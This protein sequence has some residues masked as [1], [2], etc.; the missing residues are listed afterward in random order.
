MY[1]I[2]L[3][4][5]LLACVHGYTILYPSS[6]LFN[7][8]VGN[9]SDIN[10]YCAFQSA[11]FLNCSSSQAFLFYRNSPVT[12]S[13][14]IYDRYGTLIADNQT[15]L[16]TRTDLPLGTHWIGSLNNNCGDWLS[17]GCGNAQIGR[18]G[19]LYADFWACNLP[20]NNPLLPRLPILCAC[21]DGTPLPSLAPTPQ[22]G[23]TAPT[24]SPTRRPT[25]MPV[26]GAPSRVPTFAP[27]QVLQLNMARFSSIPGQASNGSNLILFTEFRFGSQSAFQYNRTTVSVPVDGSY[28]F[29]VSAGYLDF[30]VLF[31]N[32]PVIADVDVTM[33]LRRNGLAIA[34]ITNMFESIGQDMTLTFDH[35]VTNA[36]TSDVFDVVI[37]G[38]TNLTGSGLTIRKLD[39]PV[40]T[41]SLPQ[42]YALPPTLSP[43]I[44]PITSTGSF[45]TGFPVVGTSTITAATTALHYISFMTTLSI[46]LGGSA[47]LAVRKNGV[48]QTQAYIGDSVIDDIVTTVVFYMWL[49]LVVNDI[50]IIRWTADGPVTSTATDTHQ[51]YIRV[52]SESELTTFQMSSGLAINQVSYGANAPQVLGNN[53][54]F[55]KTDGIYRSTSYT[56]VLVPNGNDVLVSLFS[57]ASPAFI[58]GL[59]DLS[60]RYGYTLANNFQTLFSRVA[61]IQ[62]LDYIAAAFTGGGGVTF[63][64]PNNAHFGAIVRIADNFSEPCF[65]VD[66]YNINCHSTNYGNVD[67]SDPTYTNYAAVLAALGCTCYSFNFL[68]GGAVR[69]L[70]YELIVGGT[71]QRCDCLQVDNS[72]STDNG[73]VNSENQPSITGNYADD[74]DAIGWTNCTDG[75]VMASFFYSD[76]TT[77]MRA[78]SYCKTPFMPPSTFLSCAFYS[79]TPTP[80]GSNYSQLYLHNVTCPL[81]NQSI[82]KLRFVKSSPSTFRFDLSCCSVEGTLSPTTPTTLVPT[83]FPSSEPSK[84]PTCLASWRQQGSKL[85]FGS[86]SRLG[87]SVASSADGS[88]VVVGLSFNSTNAG[89]VYIRSGGTWTYQGNIQADIFSTVTLYAVGI[90]DDGNTAVVG[91]ETAGGSGG[92]FIHTRSGGVWTRQGAPLIGTGEVGAD[93]YQGYAVDMSADGNT[94]V[95]GAYNDNGNA[96]AAWVFYRTGTVWAQQGSKLVG[97]GGSSSARQGESVTVSGDGK[98][99]ALGGPNDEDPFFNPGVGSVWVFVNDSGSWTQQGSKLQSGLSMGQE[100]QSVDLSYDG[101]TMIVGSPGAYGGTGAFSIYVRSAGVWS[102]QLSN[103]Q[104]SGASGSQGTSVSISA[105][106]DTVVIGGP[107]S[108]TNGANWVFVRSGVS[109]TQTLRITGSGNTGSTIRQGSSVSIADNGVAFFSGAPFDGFSDEG[110]FWPFIYECITQSPT[111]LPTPF[112]TTKNPTGYPTY[113]SPTRLPTGV[114]SGFPYIVYTAPYANI[115]INGMRTQC[116]S[117]NTYS[118]LT[119]TALVS[120]TVGSTAFLVTMSSEVLPNSVI[121]SATRRPVTMNSTKLFMDG[122]FANDLF[123]MTHPGD[124]DFVGSGV[125]TAG[126]YLVTGSF[127][128]GTMLEDA[129]TF[130]QCRI[131][132]FANGEPSYSHNGAFSKALMGQCAGK[133]NAVVNSNC[134]QYTTYNDK[135]NNCFGWANAPLSEGFRQGVCSTS[136]VYKYLCIVQADSAVT[137]AP[138]AAPA[139]LPTLVPTLQPS[140]KS[141]SLSPTLTFYAFAQFGSKLTAEIP[142][143]EAVA[144]VSI[145]GNGSV[146]V[147]GAQSETIARV[148]TRSGPSWTGQTLNFNEPST[149]VDIDT[150]GDTILV[151]NE[152]CDYIGDG[153]DYNGCVYPF[154]R[155]GSTFIVQTTFVP[156]VYFSISRFGK[157]ISL[158]GDGQTTIVGSGT[159]SNVGNTFVFIRSGLTWTEEASFTVTGAGPG[160]EIQ[161]FSVSLTED[162]NTAASGGPGDNS[163][164]GAFW[165]FNRTGVTWTQQGSKLVGTGNVGAARQG[166]S[167]SL[168]ADGNTAFSGGPSDNSNL[169]AVWVF[170][171]E[172]GIWSQQGSKLVG[173]GYVG[174]TIS[175][176][177]SVSSSSTGNMVVFG[178]IGDNFNQGAVWVFQRSGITWS[179]LGAKLTVTGNLG[180]ARVGAYIKLSRDNSTFIVG[181]P[182]DSSNRGAAWVFNRTMP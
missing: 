179:Q 162:G 175:Q 54:M 94:A 127:S 180:S 47:T 77:S 62:V 9:Q 69:G 111:R 24:T 85:T 126:E 95:S 118:S 166:T 83:L 58:F 71:T 7:G 99:I 86:G 17:G 74:L 57:S 50:I 147:I 178:A 136:G 34:S 164:I 78:A 92:L 89:L 73:Q 18:G 29:V 35:M 2:I 49:P 98:T 173:T 30:N 121:V 46:P 114:S 142:N 90:S 170:V 59:G 146:A 143:F 130:P 144:P 156:S 150:N 163:S 91:G 133:N 141:P 122:A 106:G 84:S 101:D 148:F 70:Q 169:G 40:A 152:F 151:G 97:T 172:N 19:I 65:Y 154:I 134:S 79:T 87:T 68:G 31:G 67:Y 93:V 123:N 76:F 138:T 43:T 6:D 45:G 82:Q 124:F 21:T 117:L 72:T 110:A 137:F 158:S 75:D 167:V 104:G 80:I 149:D 53:T 42:S 105:D 140:S 129:E 39:D 168:S 27:T 3:F 32:P 132:N 44:T 107:F 112:P 109:W 102:A 8:Q 52:A 51:G 153:D 33:Q 171:R 38:L 81:P 160:N 66:T 60:A 157:S 116:Q 22:P 25:K 12:L 15:D 5:A 159:S 125:C 88:T 108:G 13:T 23:S 145:S 48:T 37:V 63:Y 20:V 4:L 10:L 1:L 100:G 161:G 119:A 103:F 155:S 14:P 16:A 26:T 41:F 181:G 120:S 56:N 115:G 176:G 28:E 131:V 96:G 11:Q 113:S 61:P 177:Q 55:I 135:Y 128:D 174:T 182:D 36:V 139:A 165:I 64:A